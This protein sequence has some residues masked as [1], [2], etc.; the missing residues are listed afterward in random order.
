M[1]VGI[2]SISINKEV[3]NDV[4]KKHIVSIKGIS[5]NPDALIGIVTFVIGFG[6]ARKLGD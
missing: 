2:P 1:A 6:I 4:L 3:E 5:D